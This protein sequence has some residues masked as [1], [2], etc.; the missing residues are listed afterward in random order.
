MNSRSLNRRQFTGL[1]ATSLLSTS[2]M[3]AAPSG[4][5]AQGPAPGVGAAARRTVKL[6]DGTVVPALGQGSARLGKGRHPQAVEQE[7]LRTGISLGMTLI[8]TAEIYG[9][10]QFIGRAIAGKRDRVFLVSKVWQTHVA[11]NGIARA[12]EGSL[13]RLGTDHLDLYLLHWPQK[14]VGIS[15]IVAAFEDL[16]AKKKIRAWGVSNFGVGEMEELFRVP[17]GDRCAT[18][19]VPYNLGDRGIERDLM[20]WC[21]RHGVTIMAYSPLGGEGTKLLRD[22]ALARIAAAHGCSAAAVALAWTI[23]GGNVIAIPESGSVDHIK[24][25]AV[26][27]SLTLTPQE[28][29]TLDAAHPPGG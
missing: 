4:A 20:P 16:R 22:P 14:V 28:L 24:E 17:N 23:R 21:E 25:N 19:Q 2:A 12:C 7:A 8:D 29:Q 13:A 18:N 3:F 11:G 9:S 6:P 1:C 15:T 10:E 27:L 5:F 26:A